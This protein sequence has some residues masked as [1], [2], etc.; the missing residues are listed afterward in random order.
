MNPRRAPLPILGT[1]SALVLT[2]LLAGRARS[3]PG[4]EK[5]AAASEPRAGLEE[6]VG[7][8]KNLLKEKASSVAYLKGENIRMGRQRTFVTDIES[9]GRCELS[10]KLVR[11]GVSL[12][13]KENNVVQSETLRWVSLPLGRV[14]RGSASWSDADKNVTFRLSEAVKVKVKNTTVGQVSGQREWEEESRALW[15]PLESGTDAPGF[16]SALEH[17]AAICG[18]PANPSGD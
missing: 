5:R 16:I 4:A 17:A 10:F 15:L 3:A 1:L 18:A 9:P 7:W 14:V 13:L 11:S 12:T 8:L 2:S 6:T